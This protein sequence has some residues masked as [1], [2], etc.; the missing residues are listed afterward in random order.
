[1]KIKALLTTLVVIMSL[2]FSVSC[3]KNRE[4]DE[5]DVLYYSENLIKNSIILNE[6][7][8]G[9]GIPYTKDESLADGYYYPAS[10]EYLSKIGI[11][12]IEDI[13][14]LTRLCYTEAVSESI[15]KT[16]LSS[17]W[18][19]S[20]II[21][22]ARYYQKYNSL[23]DSEECIMV[24]KD[25]PILLTDTVEYDY[26]SLYVSGVK[27]MEVFVKITVN[28]TREDKKSQKRE[29]EIGLLE[30]SGG[31]RLNSPTYARYVDY[32]YYNDL[33]K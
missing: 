18:S 27:G 11:V 1:M 2:F 3:E 8:Y 23:D 10:S 31:W 4:Y 21:S 26:D 19:D 7:Y 17:I 28:I 5:S 22:Y 33:K 29:I 24:Y 14:E 16:K 15:I 20:G 30:E 25:S 32:D 6:I 12:N 13:K 9:S